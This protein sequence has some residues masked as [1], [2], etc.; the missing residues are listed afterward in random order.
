MREAGRWYEGVMTD[1]GGVG[2]GGVEGMEGRT[3][4]CRRSARCQMGEEIDRFPLTSCSK[5][6]DM[7]SLAVRLT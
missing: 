5:Q 2:L 6:N 3:L 7:T 4:A 1:G